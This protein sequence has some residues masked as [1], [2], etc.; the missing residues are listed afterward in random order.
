MPYLI[1]ILV[2]IVASG[3]TFFSGF[4]LGTILL[5]AFL[6]FFP[7]DIAIAATAIVHLA[8]NLFKAFLI[9]RKADC[10]TVLA[11]AL[12]GAVAAILGA[13]L[14]E[15]LGHFP[16]I[17]QYVLLGHTFSIIPIKLL[18]ACLMGV[19]A[20]L[21]LNPKFR[22]LAFPPRWLPVGG[23][24]SGFFGGLTG[25]QGAL[26]SAFLIR[27]GLDKEAFI[28]T[29]VLS[30]IVIDI[31]RLLVYGFTFLVKDFTLIASQNEAGLVMAGIFSALTGSILGS[32]FVKSVTI[33]AIQKFIGYLLV[34]YA[35]LLGF[36][37]I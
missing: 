11:F 37:F 1:V 26:R 31:S 28:G 16:P 10:I 5:P 8:N 18:V 13:I 12:P 24:L 34:I 7:V 15:R 4:G 35:I 14:L 23:L 25:H 20:W 29:T 33:E 2:T 3:L 32:R 21:E 17:Y 36:G 19:F 22:N 30:A 6:L 9:G 27:L